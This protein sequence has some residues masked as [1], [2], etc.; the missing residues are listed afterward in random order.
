LAT[1][2]AFGVIKT[3]D[4]TGP[5]VASYKMDPPTAVGF[6]RFHPLIVT[7]LTNAEFNKNNKEA[8]KITILLNIYISLFVRLQGILIIVFKR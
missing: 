7:A 4:L 8:R 1:C 5:F 6:N 2:E 3:D